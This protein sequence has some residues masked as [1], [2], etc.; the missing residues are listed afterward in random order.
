MMI[1][2]DTIGIRMLEKIDGHSDKNKINKKAGLIRD[3]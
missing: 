1:E 3:A 2:G